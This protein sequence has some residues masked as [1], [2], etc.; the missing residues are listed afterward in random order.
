MTVCYAAD[1]LTLK[2]TYDK[3][4]EAIVFEEGDKLVKLS[5][6]YENSIETLQRS[7]Q[8]AG[9]LEKL[10]AALNE[11][12]RFKDEKA[13]PTQ[14][15]EGQIEEITRIQEAY[16]NQKAFLEEGKAK[17]IV[18]LV[19]NYDR[20]L[21]KI[22][23]DY[24]R[25][26]KIDDATAVLEERNNL[27]KS[28]EV[29]AAKACISESDKKEELKPTAKTKKTVEDLKPTLTYCTSREDKQSVFDGF[30]QENNLA[31]DGKA[32]ASGQ[33]AP[34]FN[35]EN[36][37][38]SVNRTGAAWWMDKNEGWFRV[39]WRPAVTGQYIILFGKGGPPRSSSWGK[40]ELE[41]N[42]KPLAVMEE[43]FASNDILVIN[44]QKQT[45]I[46][47]L[48]CVINGKDCPGLTAIEIHK[49]RIETPVP[50]KP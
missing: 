35:P 49:E 50:P 5:G 3:A 44:L 9:N 25:A 27:T 12:N 4:L 45:E 20:Y 13:V 23:K 11:L 26:N 21:E 39:K 10:K 37:F 31:G 41:L 33:R 19:S 30:P 22:Q 34:P 42:G 17:R 2:S 7:M 36:V 16:I 40:T 14:P 1:L 29:I 15:P 48:Y 43:E 8:Q 32:T 18:A 38:K 46:K 47:E 6:S 24:T 28:P